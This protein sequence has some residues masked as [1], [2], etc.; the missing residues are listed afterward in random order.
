ML[1]SNVNDPYKAKT[2]LIKTLTI[3]NKYCIKQSRE[4]T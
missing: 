1:H 4:I 2:D 3:V